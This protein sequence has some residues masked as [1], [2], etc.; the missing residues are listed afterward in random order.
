[1]T[2]ESRVT[3][4]SS[5]VADA[6]TTDDNIKINPSAIRYIKLG[7]GNRLAEECIERGIIRLGFDGVPHDLCQTSDWSGVR[8]ILL[9]L[10]K[11]QGAATNQANQIEDFYTLRGDV[12]WITFWDSKLW[13]TFA[14]PGVHQDEH[15]DYLTRHR[16]VATPWR[17]TNIRGD[18]LA[19]R[20]F[21]T[22]LT[23]TAGFRGTICNIDEAPYL[24]RRINAESEPLA[25]EA[26]TLQNQLVA[27]AERLVAALHWRDF[28][29]LVDRIFADSGWRR[30]GVLG[31]T[32]A[33]V[34]LIVEQTAT[35]ERAFV[36]VKSR[37][38]P[39]VL[40]DYVDRYREY[41]DCSRMFFICHSPKGRLR[42]QAV[43]ADIE[44]WFADTI[45]R[46]AVRA[47]QYEWLVQRVA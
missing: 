4:S 23:K 37:A 29:I 17:C 36:Q 34:D 44:L 2:L 32:Q 31:E 45:A 22:R 30:V 5:G 12:L 15:H 7:T 46:K 16:R 18:V 13:W 28:E 25:D 43:S 1:M 39:A 27:M 14:Q 41:G 38:T 8:K 21:S 19:L 20:N 6:A 33:D 42:Q 40:Q 26:A 3:L 35:G 11:T 10:G 47:G 9:D 24:L